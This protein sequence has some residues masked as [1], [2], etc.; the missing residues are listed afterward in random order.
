M[1]AGLA[2]SRPTKLNQIQVNAHKPYG[3]MKQDWDGIEPMELVQTNSKLQ[4][5]D[6]RRDS[7]GKE[8][9]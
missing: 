6:A 9:I 1:G 7:S 3:I 8:H 2:M 4:E 5:G